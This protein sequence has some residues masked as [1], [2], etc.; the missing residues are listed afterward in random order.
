MTTIAQAGHLLASRD[1][2]ASFSPVRLGGPLPAAAL[3]SPTAG[4]IVIA[5]PRGVSAQPLP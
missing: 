5:G 3:L 2:G 4:Q 1:D